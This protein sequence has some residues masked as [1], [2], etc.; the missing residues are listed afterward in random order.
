MSRSAKRWGGGSVGA[1]ILR[2]LFQ[3]VLTI[4]G[5]MLV[6]FL[7]FRMVAGD[8]AAAQLGQR[9]T[10]QEKAEWRHRYGY[11]MPLVLNVHNQLVVE[12][13]TTGDKP[14]AARAVG[15]P[16][17]AMAL[18]PE[19]VEAEETGRSD[20]VMGRY[21]MGLTPDSPAAALLGL[22]DDQDAP[23]AEA[24]EDSSLV[25]LL[26][27]G[28]E[29]TVPLAG[30]STV[31]DVLN[32]INAA[33]GNDGKVEAR[34]RNWRLGTITQS[35]FFDHLVTSITF[36]ARS[37]ANNKKLT[38]ILRER[39]P[40]SLALTIPSLAIGW[41]LALLIASFVAYYR[42]RWIDHVVVF[43]SVLGMCLPYLAFMMYGQW[44]M[45]RIAPS[46]AYGLEQRV[47]IYVPIAITVIAGLGV[48]VR[49]YRTVILDQVGQDYVR[50]A[51]AK[52]LPLRTVLF[53]HVLRNCMLPIL[54]NLVLAIPFLILGNLLAESFF[55]IN[56]LGSLMINSIQA[57]DEPV[58]NALVFLTALIYTVGLL[59]TD[60]SYAVFD[61]RIRLT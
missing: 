17:D 39:A 25:L 6:T 28:S 56:G 33:A 11:D 20:L 5:V 7:L 4:F 1:F 44:L 15:E 16:A 57:R 24:W 42:G 31:G 45:F 58:I 13:K 48:S 36:D 23:G 8:I 27:D 26:A 34:I 61:P 59:I 60:I 14:F 32:R 35:Q 52:G 18:V 50:T 12:D 22:D 47:N 41:A 38:T 43:L 21:V 53:K 2:R 9:A 30:V 29:L 3:S 10:Q 49:F 40:F 51:R 54:T 37:L 19:A 46:H 55:G